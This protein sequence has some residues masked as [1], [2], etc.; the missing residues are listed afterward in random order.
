[1]SHPIFPGEKILQSKIPGET[2]ESTKQKYGKKR[3]QSEQEGVRRGEAADMRSRTMGRERLFTI[4]PPDHFISSQLSLVDRA[5]AS[6]TTR[7][8]VQWLY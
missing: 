6:Q 3:A 2:C 7:M 1:M 4:N 8:E 5:A